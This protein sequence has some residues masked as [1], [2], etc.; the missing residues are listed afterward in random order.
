MDLSKKTF[1]AV[2]P[3]GVFFFAA[4]ILFMIVFPACAQDDEPLVVGVTESPP[5]SFKEDGEWKGLSLDIWQNVSKK[6]QVEYEIRPFTVNELLEAIR[7]G[8][9]DI[10]AAALFT[11]A[12]RELFMNFTHS[13]YSG[14]LGIATK[15]ERGS[16]WRVFFNLLT[17]GGFLRV[18]FMLGAVLFIVGL[19]IWMAE[20]KVNPDHF[21]RN[22]VRGIGSGFWFSAVTMTTV[23]YGDKAPASFLGLPGWARPIWR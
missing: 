15:A 14:G 6:M 1:P 10:A 21:P 12:E 3:R 19:I 7:Q 13:F 23:G 9:A 17:S 4:L 20:R 5:F 16:T 11:T 8:K 22:P 2:F 18:L